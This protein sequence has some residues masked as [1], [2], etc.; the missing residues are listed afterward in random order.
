MRVVGSDGEGFNGGIAETGIRVV[1]GRDE[2]GSIGK[3][4][5]SNGEECNT[6]NE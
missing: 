3:R 2:K 1:D 4:R 5:G 6:V